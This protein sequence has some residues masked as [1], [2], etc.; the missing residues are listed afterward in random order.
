MGCQFP[1]FQ[2]GWVSSSSVGPTSSDA[3][4]DGAVIMTQDIQSGDITVISMNWDTQ[5]IS[6]EDKS[7]TLKK[8][9]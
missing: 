5:D 7:R 2:A 8:K 4:T 1:P 9:A 3:I 6:N